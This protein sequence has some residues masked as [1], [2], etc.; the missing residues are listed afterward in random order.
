M[1]GGDGMSIIG[2][3]HVYGGDGMSMDMTM[4]FSASLCKYN[5]RGMQGSKR[6]VSALSWTV[7][8]IVTVSR[9][10]VRVVRPRDV[11]E[12]RNLII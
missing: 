3:P 2:P 7:C 6:C 11:S 12:P 9:G 1:C 5:S 8:D 4:G 10:G